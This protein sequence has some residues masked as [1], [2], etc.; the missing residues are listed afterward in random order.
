MTRS[1]SSTSSADSSSLPV[2]VSEGWAIAY[3]SDGA[4]R[5]I[6][7]F[8]L[9]ISEAGTTSRLGTA[10][11]PPL[12]VASVRASRR[13]A[14]RSPE[15]SCPGP[16]RRPGRRRGRVAPGSA[17]SSGRCADRAAARRATPA[18]WEICRASGDLSRSSVAS[19][20][21]PAVKPVHSRVVSGRA[22]DTSRSSAAPA[23]KRIPS[24]K[25][26]PLSW[27]RRSMVCQCSSASASFS[28]SISTHLPL[29]RTS[30]ST[31]ASN[32]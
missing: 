27:T 26:S 32:S 13:A 22:A 6:S 14:G 9:A 3:V 30:P 29:S 8:Q 15:R 21:G 31:E 11:P 23:S 12:P 18:G 2:V 24:K 17:A 19:R 7:A 16:C 20:P 25:D 28:R 10:L 4:N 1:Q 5:S